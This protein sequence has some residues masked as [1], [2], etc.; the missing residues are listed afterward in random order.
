[1]PVKIENAGSIIKIK[2]NELYEY[3][4]R[5]YNNFYNS[6][7]R[8]IAHCERELRFISDEEQRRLW[9]EIK[10]ELKKNF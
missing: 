3:Y 8:S 1:M 5:D 2:A 4:E 6:K 10:E 9:I 7:A